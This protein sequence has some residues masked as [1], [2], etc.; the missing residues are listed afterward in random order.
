LAAPA[1]RRV[2]ARLAAAACAQA[3]ARVLLWL[4]AAF[5]AV[6]L[7]FVVQMAPWRALDDWRLDAADSVETPGK[8]AEAAPT[9]MSINKRTVWRYRFE[10]RAE[11]ESRTGMC[12]TAGQS[13]QAGETVTV[14]HRPG[15]AGV[16]VVRGARTSPGGSVGFVVTIIAVIGLSLAAWIFLRRR[17]AMRLLT[18][19]RLTD[20]LVAAM[21]KTGASVNYQPVFKVSLRILD[22]AATVP[23]VVRCYAPEVVTFAETRLQSGQP[24][25]VLFDPTR[26]NYALLPEAL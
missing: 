13:W 10:F 21:E 12:F 2:P 9:G 11:G 16:A 20:A 24:V 19:G 14:R 6:G 25:F 15:N 22:A 26:P 1:P 23:V 3:G 17:R 4:G 5:G 18:H 8:I 7:L